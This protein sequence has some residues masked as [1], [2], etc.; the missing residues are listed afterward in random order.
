MHKARLTL[1]AAVAIAL[2]GFAWLILRPTPAPMPIVD[3][4]G[5]VA[6]GG[7]FTLT[8]ADGKPFVSSSIGKPAAVFFGFTHCPDVCPTTIAR[9][10]RLRR[11]LGKGEGAMDI[12]FITV[13]PERDGPEEVGA[14]SGLFGTK[15]IGLTGSPA[16]I[17]KVKQQFG[18][19][20]EK[21]P[22]TGSA[23]Y[24]V[25]HTATVF[26]MD[27]D[28]QFQSTIAAEENDAAAL[29]KLGRLTA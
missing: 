18:V 22:A 16:E 13:D 29:A 2:A 17:D 27:R 24:N 10:A 1:W 15:V 23:D 11:Q 21:Q 12:V 9:L 20:S 7:P 28:G 19:Y 14:Y 5:A 8:G 6:I 26:L 25:A 4:S 3:G